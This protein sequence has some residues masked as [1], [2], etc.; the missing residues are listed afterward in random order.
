[1]D[2]EIL[3]RMQFA[4][5]VMFHYIFPPLSIGLGLVLV[6]MEF[7]YLRTG[8]VL[9]HNMARYW[10][11][12]FALTFAIGVASGIVM[13]FQ[14]GTNWATYSRFVGDVFGSPLAA[15]GI[16]AFFL[17][18]GFLAVLL[19]GWDKVGPKMHFFSTLMV[20]L[21]SHFS[22][23]WIV[24]AN[25]W[26]Q[27]PAGY[28]FE[29]APPGTEP[30]FLPAETEITAEMLPHTRAVIDS[31]WELV[32][33]PSTV[34]RLTH[35]VIGAWLAGAFLV[36]S[37]SAWYLLKKRHQ[38]FAT[39]SIKFGMAFAVFSALLQLWSGHDSAQQVA[40]EQP[41]KLAAMEGI[42]E[43]TTHAPLDLIGWV[44]EE[45]ESK[46]SIAVPGMLSWLAWG[47]FSAEVVGLDQIPR[48]D[49][50]PVNRVYVSFHVMVAIGMALIAIALFGCFLWWR[51]KL[52]DVDKPVSK[53]YLRLLVPAVLLPMIANQLGWL[54]A[55]FGRQPWVVWHMLRTEDALSKTVPANHVLASLIGF[56]LVYALLL[57]V[58]IYLLNKKI[59]TGPSDVEESSELPEKWRDILKH[60]GL[61]ET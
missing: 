55:E 59:Q 15:E 38:R 23:I 28:Q 22:A 53:W 30:V 57:A 52:F 29:Y 54:T 7:M 56:M 36:L 44:D 35:V 48:E 8:E 3:S 10:T 50:P 32:F 58:F 60:K 16:F 41:A 33:N 40:E 61:A 18:S 45:N 34:E 4:F 27:T 13:E 46:W 2:V 37:V 39:T 43:T 47:D 9:Y 31:F 6:L 25:S 21:G 42:F 24:V 1:M 17:E 51:G 11:K 20:C 26:M 5:T 19:F 49:W 12:I 14:F